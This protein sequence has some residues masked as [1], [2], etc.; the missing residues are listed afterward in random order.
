MARVGRQARGQASSRHCPGDRL[1]ASWLCPSSSGRLASPGLSLCRQLLAFLLHP[2]SARTSVCSWGP[3]LWPQPAPGCCS[4]GPHPLLW[5]RSS[6][7]PGLGVHAWLWGPSLSPQLFPKAPPP[8]AVFSPA[9]LLSV[10]LK[11][12]TQMEPLTRGLLG[13]QRLCRG[14]S[15]RKQAGS[16]RPEG[17]RGEP[18]AS[19]GGL[20]AGATDRTRDTGHSHPCGSAGRAWGMDAV[21]TLLP[22]PPAGPPHG[23]QQ[24]GGH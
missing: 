22:S 24:A 6:G 15:V 14:V 2:T 18:S 17:R 1:L 16:T 23:E 12:A 20:S 9:V 7:A 4:F 19:Q 11:M 13:L 3:W 8:L 10:L 21:N 5:G